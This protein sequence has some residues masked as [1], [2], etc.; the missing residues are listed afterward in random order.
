M[1]VHPYG[2]RVVLIQPGDINTGIAARRQKTQ[3][4]QGSTYQE[5]LDRALAV[6]EKDEVTGPPPETI[7]LLVQRIIETPTPGCATSP[8]P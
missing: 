3:A 2:I 1:E 7:A 6:M 8:R 5:M 4:A